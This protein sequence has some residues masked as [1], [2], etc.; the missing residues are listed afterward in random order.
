[1]SLDLQIR[2]DILLSL[3]KG[4]GKERLDATCAPP[5]EPFYPGHA[6]VKDAVIII[7][8]QTAEFKVETSVFVVDQ[9]SKPTSVEFL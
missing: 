1:M 4:N 9:A 8:N 2:K 5:F 6:D 3:V 7:G